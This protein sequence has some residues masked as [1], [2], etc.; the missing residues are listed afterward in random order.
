MVLAF[1]PTRLSASFVVGAVVTLCASV[2]IATAQTAGSPAQQVD[3]ASPSLDYEYF[4]TQVEPIF[5]KWRSPDH[6]R[7]YTCH[8]GVKHN[9]GLNLESL[10]PGQSFWTEEQSRRNFEIVSKLVVPGDLSSSMF[11]MHPLAPE[12]GGD[13]VRVHGGGRQFESQEDPDF[14]RIAD[15]VRGKK[16]GAPSNP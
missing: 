2:A 6:A 10:L 12:A 4:K 13:S 5:L 14:Q 15:W 9:T 16:A 7:C 1:L 3:S 8:Q 11:P